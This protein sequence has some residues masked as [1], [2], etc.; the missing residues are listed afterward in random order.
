MDV[1]TIV[2]TGAMALYFGGRLA[3]AGIPVRF[4]GTWEAG[5]AAIKTHGIHLQVG[6]EN[7]SYSAQSTSD[8]SLLYPSDLVLVLVK[9]W[10]TSRAAKPWRS[11]RR[12]LVRSGLP[13]V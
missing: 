11:C 3:G 6:D 9:S 12:S 4:L 13:R 8:V 10:Q 2:G 5:L 7:S 1:V